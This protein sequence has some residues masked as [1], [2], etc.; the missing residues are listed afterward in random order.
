[1]VGTCHYAVLHLSKPK[2]STT[3]RINPNVN[4]GLWVIIMCQFGL[5]SYKNCPILVGDID[6]GKGCV[7]GEVKG[8]LW[9]ISVCFAQFCCEPKTALKNKVH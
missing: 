7:W 6:N 3:T 9:E 2:A 5:I 8:V 1:M 4:Y